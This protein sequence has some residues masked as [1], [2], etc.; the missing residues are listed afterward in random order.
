MDYYT[1][2]VTLAPGAVVLQ[3]AF[4]YDIWRLRDRLTS[5]FQSVIAVVIAYVCA[6]LLD[7]VWASLTAVVVAVLTLILGFWLA[8]GPD[9]HTDDDTSVHE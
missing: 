9:P 1:Y 4:L 7:T 5:Y 2:I 8:F 6:M 3:M